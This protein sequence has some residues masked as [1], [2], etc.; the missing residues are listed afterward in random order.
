[1][2]MVPVADD[3]LL[4]VLRA[5]AASAPEPLYPGKLA[6]VSGLERAALDQGL[7]QLRLRGLVQLTDWV[8]GK[9]QGYALT[10]EG[11]LILTDPALL[12]R[13]RQAAPAKEHSPEREINPWSRG[14]EVRDA[15]LNPVR[16]VACMG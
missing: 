5:I 1:M 13:P 12:N 8:Q 15:L 4:K 3:L 9:G 14:E 10:A 16:P 7:D 2:T 11:A 6:A